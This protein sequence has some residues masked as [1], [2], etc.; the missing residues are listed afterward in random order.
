MKLRNA[1]TMS[2]LKVMETEGKE[3]GLGMR[4]Q[5]VSRA[6]LA[7]D[8]FTFLCSGFALVTVGS[9]FGPLLICLNKPL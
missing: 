7:V 5:P 6:Y 2:N 8:L 9:F 3:P 1:N 4:T